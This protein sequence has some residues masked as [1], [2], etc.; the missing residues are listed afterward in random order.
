MW[1]PTTQKDHGQ[2]W[3]HQIICESIYFG[4]DAVIMPSLLK[5]SLSC[6]FFSWSLV[7]PLFLLHGGNMTDKSPLQIYYKQSGAFQFTFHFDHGNWLGLFDGNLRVI[8]FTALIA[9]PPP[10]HPCKFKCSFF[11]G[12]CQ[13]K[14]GHAWY[15]IPRDG[16]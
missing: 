13:L 8:S 6:F 12:S 2:L 7:F 10:L 16:S 14:R 3:L 5:L 15:I 11:Q 4:S 1:L 9:K